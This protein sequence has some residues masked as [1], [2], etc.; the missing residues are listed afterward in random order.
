MIPVTSFRR[1]A[2]SRSV[3]PRRLGASRLRALKAGGA[4]VRLGRQSESVAKARGRRHHRPSIC[5]AP[6]GGISAFVLSP[7]VPLT[8]PKPHWTVELAKGAGVEIIGDIEL[9]FREQAQDR[10]A[11]PFVAITGTNGKSTTTA[12]IAHPECARP[13]ATRRWAAISARAVLTLEPPARPHPCH[14]MLVLPDRSRALAQ[15]D[16]RH[17]AQPDAGSSR[18]SR[19]HGSTTPRSRSAW[20]PAARPPSSASTTSIA[21]RSPTG[22]SAPASK[23]CAYPSAC[24]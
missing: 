5:V 15:P 10:A 24:L 12:L 7:G 6:T 14:R 1:Q 22:L 16:G 4:E 19:H 17:P 9:F 20:S 23:S 2:T 18:P 13:A 3:R 21:P 11:A 8:H